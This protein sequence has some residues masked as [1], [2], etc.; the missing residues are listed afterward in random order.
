[1]GGWFKR[2][3][4]PAGKAASALFALLLLLLL[5]FFLGWKSVLALLWRL[6][7]V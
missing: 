3:V 1:M 2:A 5:S 6:E 7:R 4:V